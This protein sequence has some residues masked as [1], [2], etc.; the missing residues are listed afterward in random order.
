[1]QVGLGYS[2]TQA[3]LG[4]V[5]AR[6]ASVA[7]SRVAARAAACLGHRVVLGAGMATMGVAFASFARIGAGSDYVTTLLPGLVVLGLGIPLLF[8]SSAAIAVERIPSEHTGVGSG[9]LSTCQWLGG[10]VGVTLVPA[11]GPGT[12]HASLERLHTAFLTCA[13]IAGLGLVL[14]LALTR[15]RTSIWRLTCAPS[16]D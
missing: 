16:V 13:G 15:T 6:A 7:S 4:L 1:M 14:A 5:A 9:L 2:T 12:P 3:G 8:V 10:A 11:I